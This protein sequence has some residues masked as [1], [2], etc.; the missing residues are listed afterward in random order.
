[1]SLEYPSKTVKLLY[2][3]KCHLKSYFSFFRCQIMTIIIKSILS[4]SELKLLSKSLETLQ[5]SA[6]LKI[7]LKIIL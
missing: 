5:S 1:M 2:L 6:I 3:K 7:C 4:P